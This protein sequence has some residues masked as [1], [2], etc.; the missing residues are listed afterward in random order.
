MSLTCHLI[1]CQFNNTLK[2][3]KKIVNFSHNKNVQNFSQNLSIYSNNF[4]HNNLMSQSKTFIDSV[5]FALN[6]IFHRLKKNLCTVF[7]HLCIELCI[8][9]SLTFNNRF[10]PYSLIVPVRSLIVYKVISQ[11][12]CHTVRDAIYSWIEF[13]SCI[14][15]FTKFL[16]FVASICFQCHEFTNFD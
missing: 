2:C 14:I 13:H 8:I 9:S 11:I 15:V 6:F 10:A 7:L 16:T 12:F 1:R 5:R 4:S 3:R